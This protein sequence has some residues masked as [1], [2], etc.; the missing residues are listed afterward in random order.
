MLSF[1]SF[2]QERRAFKAEIYATY[3]VRGAMRVTYLLLERLVVLTE[4]VHLAL[5]PFHLILFLQATLKSTFPVLEQASLT[6]SEV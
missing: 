6:L 3:T 1:S 2:L 4:F 5:E